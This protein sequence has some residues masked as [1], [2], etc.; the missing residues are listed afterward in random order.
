MLSQAGHK[1]SEA[2]AHSGWRGGRGG[3]KGYRK[4]GGGVC[5]ERKGIV[6]RKAKGRIKMQGRKIILLSCTV[7]ATQ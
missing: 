6:M 2:S 5:S 4:V 1:A 3:K 7:G